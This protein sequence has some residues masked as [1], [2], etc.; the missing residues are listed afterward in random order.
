MKNFIKLVETAH[1]ERF[2]V[3]ANRLIDEKIPVAFLS[4]SSFENAVAMVRENKKWFNITNLITTAPPHSSDDFQIDCNVTDLKDA[5]KIY[6]RPEYIL[7]A[8]KEIAWRAASKYFPNCTNLELCG[9]TFAENIYDVFMQHLSELQEVYKS[10]I[11]EES[12]KTFCGYWLGIITRQFAKFHHAEGAHYITAGFI[13]EPNSILIDG[14]VCD[15]A[16][17]LR[18]TQMGY[19]V[20]GFE[21]DRENFVIAKE[22]SEKNN[23]AVEN[24]GLG[25]Y[26]R[27][28]K[29]VH[30]PGGG[31]G[32][33]R[34]NSNG[35]ET[36]KIIPLDLY[37]L[38]KNI[39]R[40][41]CI[42]LDVEGAEL[43][44][45]KG[46]SLTIKRWKPIL[47]LSAYHK[48]DDFWTLMN[49]IKA[50][51]PDYEF[52]LRHYTE[53][54]NEMVSWFYEDGSFVERLQNLG[55]EV[56]R[57]NFNECCLLAR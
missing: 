46:A 41:D 1:K 37:V 29:Y 57:K 31:I 49:F 18:F 53:P 51:R 25:A 32:S 11:D 30:A 43:D 9:R 8:D 6:P 33:S 40:V 16:S 56:T 2:K 55:L 21:M 52:A 44:V 12:R 27:E 14:G 24:L 35:T 36:A 47:L 15:G 23:F 28:M 19:K 22:L 38:E 26:V 13:P 20:Y 42:K 34:L 7:T 4:V 45:L 17:S 54:P 39:P 48:P 3:V 50:L 5:S 10:L